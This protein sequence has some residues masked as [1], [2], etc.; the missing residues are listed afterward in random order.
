MLITLNGIQFQDRRIS[1]ETF[2]V[3]ELKGWYATSSDKLSVVERAQ[4]HGSFSNDWTARESLGISMSVQVF[5]P[6]EPALLQVQEQLT[7]IGFDVPV[8]MRVQDSVRVTERLVTVR[9]VD[10]PDHR[11]RRSNVVTFDLLAF[12]PRR[13]T[14]AVDAPWVSGVPYR[15]TG[16]LRWPLRWPLVW[17]ERGGSDGRIRLTNSGRKPSPPV[18]RVYGPFTSVSITNV[19]TQQV[20]SFALPVAAG[21]FVE[22]D[23]RKR[24]AAIGGDS[25]ASRYLRS[26][27]WWDV[28]AQSTTTAQV[29]G[30][31]FTELTRFEGQ[32]RSAW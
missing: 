10:V 1:A 14:P 22:F 27:Q 9:N 24:Q 32:V 29:L 28:P 31:G 23:F 7:S 8:V 16:G 2:W 19:D 4:A 12:D 18:Y 11:K 20:V 15:A 13:Y 25:D 30:D 6:D 26:R 5:A 3:R 17:A 21:S